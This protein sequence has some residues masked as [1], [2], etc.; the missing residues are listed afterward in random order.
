MPLFVCGSFSD[1]VGKR[2]HLRCARLVAPLA[3]VCL[4]G[5]KAVL[6]AVLVNRLRR[7]KAIKISSI[8]IVVLS[9][10]GAHFLLSA[11]SSFQ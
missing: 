4:A 3:A 10:F 11:E 1:C 7:L 9:F 8:F 5:E 2:K 6:L